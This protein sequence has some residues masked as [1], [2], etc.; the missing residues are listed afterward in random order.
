[1]ARISRDLLVESS[2]HIQFSFNLP[3]LYLYLMIS[4]CL[5]EGTPYAQR[6][7]RIRFD[8]PRHSAEHSVNTA[9]ILI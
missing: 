9:C 5:F 7:F 4:N 8:I 2:I 1:M 3:T 6:T